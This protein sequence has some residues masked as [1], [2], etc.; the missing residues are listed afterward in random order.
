M[1]KK[2]KVTMSF[3][4]LDTHMIKYTFNG[5]SVLAD[6]TWQL[7]KTV[8]ANFLTNDHILYISTLIIRSQLFCLIYRKIKIYISKL[9]WNKEMPLE[10]E[11]RKQ[12]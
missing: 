5:R 2:N 12:A 7:I 4:S 3:F 9:E 6:V 11:E 10:N 1:R 8:T